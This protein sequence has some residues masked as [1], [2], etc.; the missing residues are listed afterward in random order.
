M[1]PPHSSPSPTPLLLCSFVKVY[2]SSFISLAGMFALRGLR[3]FLSEKN[4]FICCCAHCLMVTC[5]PMFVTFE[6]ELVFSRA[7][8]LGGHRLLTVLSSRQF[9]FPLPCWGLEGLVVLYQVP[10][11]PPIFNCGEI[12]IPIT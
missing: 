7:C 10:P 2:R 1:L 6:C 5:F 8:A 12:C 9:C 11:N 4:I 3:F